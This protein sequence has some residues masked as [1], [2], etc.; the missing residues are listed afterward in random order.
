[1]WYMLASITFLLSSTFPVPLSSIASFATKNNL[2]INVY[3]VEDSKVIYP[4]RV[5]QEVVPSRHVDLL[6]LAQRL[7]HMFIRSIFPVVLHT[8]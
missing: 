7:Q 4:L 6:L 3:N 5:L 2:S 1:M 8:K